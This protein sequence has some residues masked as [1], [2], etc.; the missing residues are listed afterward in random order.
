VHRL[1]DV[2]AG[3]VAPVVLRQVVALEAR[4]IAEEELVRLGVLQPRVNQRPARE[5]PQ[6]VVRVDDGQRVAQ[7][8]LAF[9][10]IAAIAR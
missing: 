4:V 10:R 1:H 5:V 3:G 9:S 2:V 6:V 8:A 7:R